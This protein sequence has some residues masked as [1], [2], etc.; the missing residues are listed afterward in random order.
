MA[1]L[2]LSDIPPTLEQH[3]ERPGA[4][5]LRFWGNGLYIFADFDSCPVRG[6]TAEQSARD[7]C[8]RVTSQ[9]AE[10]GILPSSPP[11]AERWTYVLPL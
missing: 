2:P 4:V 5:R 8:R 11:E 3:P 6:L 10:P 1:Y 9:E 7:W